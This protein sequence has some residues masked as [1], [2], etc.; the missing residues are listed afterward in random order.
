MLKRRG[1]A[2]GEREAE[3]GTPGHKY[4]RMDNLVEI[5][6]GEDGKGGYRDVCQQVTVTVTVTHNSERKQGVLPATEACPRNVGTGKLRVKGTAASQHS[7][8][9]KKR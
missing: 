2:Q 1:G 8:K 4:G 3:R 5:N 9:K 7:E 6:R